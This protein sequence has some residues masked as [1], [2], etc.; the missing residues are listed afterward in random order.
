MRRHFRHYSSCCLPIIL[1]LPL[2]LLPLT[3]A[4]A[5]SMGGNG[6]DSYGYDSGGTYHGSNY[7]NSE[8]NVRTRIERGELWALEVSGGVIGSAFVE[9]A[10]PERFPQIASWNA[11]PDDYS[12]WFLYGLIVHPEHQGQGWG[13]VLLDGIY[14]KFQ[15]NAPS[16]LLLDCWAG[17]TKLRRFYTDAGFDLHG[18]FPEGSYE[19]A[20]FRRNFSDCSDCS[21]DNTH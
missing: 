5:Q 12:G 14:C 11:V 13:G 15:P 21:K 10:T 6:L 16:V 3:P 8:Q 18:V 2:T 7:G 17:S 20:V 9:P 4:A 1:L 19:I